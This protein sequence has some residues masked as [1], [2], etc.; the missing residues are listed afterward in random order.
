MVVHLRESRYP[1]FPDALADMDD[2]LSMVHMFASLPAEKRIQTKRTELCLRLCREWQ[3]YVV[4]SKSLQKVFV[5]VKGMYYQAKVQGV[6]VTWVVPH[7]FSQAMPDDVDYRIMLTFLEFYEAMLQFVFFKLYHSVGLR[8]PPPLREDMDAAGAHL[9]VVDL[10]AAA[11]TDAG[12]TAA[13]E[14]DQP[15]AAIK[16]D[17]SA[18]R[19]TTLSNKLRKIRDGDDGSDDDDAS[20][21][22]SD[23][24]TDEDDAAMVAAGSD[25]EAAEEARATKQALREQ[26]RFARLFR[27]L[28]FFLSREVPREAVEFVIRSVGGEVGWQGP[29]STFDENDRSIT[30]YVTDRPGTPKKIQGREYVQPQWV[31]DSVNARV[32]LP[33]HKYAVGADL[34]V[35]VGWIEMWPVVVC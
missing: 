31:F 12:A 19:V 8:Y 34:P 33:V 4:Q 27:G 28:V 11:A 10:A 21:S 18:S 35:R 22:D 13:E 2:A 16:D 29:G 17:P 1:R 15:V 24:D 26:K 25:E 9:A 7:K 5:S 6:D 32:Q 30:H 20:G 14:G 23:T 3:A